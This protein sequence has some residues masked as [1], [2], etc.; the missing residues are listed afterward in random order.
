MNFKSVWL[1]VLT[2]LMG[3]ASAANI[4]FNGGAVAACPLSG[5]TY[6]CTAGFSMGATDFAVIASGYT[7]VVAGFSPSYNQGLTI[8]SGGALQSS[9]NIDLSNINPGN[10]S[11]GGT[12]LTAAGYFKLGSSTTINGSVVAASINT[13]SGDTITGSVTVNGLADLGSAIKINGNLN[14]GSV[15]SDSPGAVGGAISASTTV[16][17]GSGWTVG[18]NISGTTI[19]TNSPVTLNGSVA[20]SVSF[21]LASGSKVTGNISAPTVTLNPSSSTVTGNITTT[22]TLDIGSGNTVNGNVNSGALT[23]RASGAT[24]NGS[25]N[26]SGDVD[27]GSGTVINGDLT[28]RNVT[29]HAS[30]A[31]INGNAAV[32]AIYI[33]WNNSVTKTITC[34]GPGAVACSCV[35][36]ADP[37]YKPTCGAAA[38]GVPHHFQ[39]T[40]GGSALT[41]QP[42]TVTLTACANAAC[43]APHYSG[44]VTATLSPGDKATTITTGTNTAATVQ[45][46]TAGVFTLSASSPGVTNATTC[47]NTGAVIGGNACNMEFKTSGLKV[48]ATNHVSMR[49]ASVT[50]Q[51]LQASAP[52]QSCVPLVANKTVNL[53]MTCNYADPVAARAAK[54]KVFV[55]SSGMECNKDTASVS[56]AFDANGKATAPLSYAEI[57][58]VG[59]SA[60]YATSDFVASGSGNFYAA[61]AALM[62]TATSPFSGVAAIGP[63]ALNSK[64]GQLN[65]GFAKAG[66]AVAVAITAYNDQGVQTRNFGQENTPHTIV[67]TLDAVNPEGGGTHGT[68]TPG[69]SVSYSG[70]AINDSLSFSDVGVYQFTIKLSGDYYMNQQQEASFKPTGTQLIGRIIPDHFDTVLMTDAE[71]KDVGSNTH[72][73]CA[74]LAD[75]YNPCKYTGAGSRFVNSRQPFYLKVLARNLAGALTTNY[76]GALSRV[77]TVSAVTSN[78]GGTPAG[79]AADAIS[80]SGGDSAARFSFTDGTG[81]LTRPPAPASPNLPAFKFDSAYPANVLPATIYLRA[82]DADGA[83]SQRNPASDS[84]E[85]PLTVVSGRLRVANAYG[86]T[87]SP[88]PVDTQAQYYMPAGYVFNGQVND[89][90]AGKVSAYIDF[91]NCQNALKNNDGSCKAVAVTDANAVLKLESGVGKVRLTP[92]TPAVTGIGSIDVLLKKGGVDLIPYLP[93]STGRITFGVY[94]SGPVIYTREIY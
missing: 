37:N 88:L 65:T 19:T 1:I 22:G 58:L 56:L 61:P 29:T 38:G 51:A 46:T 67:Y 39:I 12:T 31:I 43:T 75:S 35:T 11:T 69:S 87:T 52:N 23:M 74:G 84:V 55:G 44:S 63:A 82:V 85:A 15:K 10:V 41:C 72:A 90:S 42:Q 48:S 7:V 53:S 76:S 92:P 60:S 86:S 33:D 18:G 91:V 32:N 13:N 93:S 9:G 79:S 6:N 66:P 45:S 70:G 4:N 50:I 73:L 25:V 26:I 59:L 49:D 68:L 14:A 81:V 78:G 83:S 40:H 20:A 62:L 80:W 36:K 30:N 17:I 54:I 8:N 2:M 3:T 94:R 16:Q 77:I 24:I 71:I 57:G 27:M 47:I 34:T 5:S 28:A 21:T 64:S 89:S